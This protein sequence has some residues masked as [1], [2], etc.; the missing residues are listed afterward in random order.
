MIKRNGHFRLNA[1]ALALASVGNAWALTPADGTPDF[2]LYVPG[3]QANDPAFGFMVGTTNTN[4]AAIVNSVCEQNPSTS[5]TND[6]TVTSTHIY[7][8]GGIN[9]NY[10]A[11][12]CW[13][14]ETLI[15]GLTTGV[16]G[17]STGTGASVQHHTKLLISRRRLGASGVGLDAIA[18]GTHLTFLSGND[19]TATVTTA[20]STSSACVF[21]TGTAA[22]YS[23]GGAYYP[24][25]YNCPTPTDTYAASVA[26]SDVTPDVFWASENVAYGTSAI[27]PGQINN[28]R[29]IGG[30][31]IGTPV[32]VQLRNALQYAEIQAGMLP[33]TCTVGNEL[34][35]CVP[36]LTKEQLSSI[37]SGTITDW[38]QFQVNVS[39][40]LADVV[41]AGVSAG[42]AGLSSPLDTTV[43]I[44]RREPGAGQQVAMLADIMQYPCL[45][46]AAPALVT[47]SSFSDVQYATSLGA[48]DK[49]LT[50]FSSSTATGFFGT[51]N[52]GV[53]NP[54]P[55]STA[56][57]NQWA[58][59]I[60][61]TERNASL[62]SP[63]RF[64]AID[65]A[66]P[67]AE[68]A[69]LGH[70]RLVGD[71]AMSWNTT[72]ANTVAVITAIANYSSLPTTISAR[73]ISLSNQKFGQAGYIAL[74]DDLYTR[75]YTPPLSWQPPGSASPS[76]NYLITP[77]SKLDNSL[78]PNACIIPYANSV[79]S[80]SV[81]LLN[82][83]GDGNN[84]GGN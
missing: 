58:I 19:V 34:A 73:N 84:L 9:D 11:V 66:L 39:Q 71:Y 47:S 24:F 45:G 25:N 2:T 12:Y 33:S 78:T 55:A 35:G 20:S 26:T 31:V 27:L 43:H 40:T 22:A 23:S 56:H 13:T 74:I 59:S 5:A 81:P 17:T 28:S 57:G 51:T 1:I 6:D 76:A 75:G 60:Q 52:T 50:T 29:A 38:T 42:V 49:C 48:V 18:H 69:W 44:C 79:S 62:G 32:T 14:N 68:E 70:Y 82:G 80:G 63:Y 64:I 4:G 53:P 36:S 15:P 7:F 72:D 10:S 16:P 30:H 54:S 3:S 83:N 41:A 8:Q 77:Y 46:T 61:T 65:W 37:F 21:T 67:T